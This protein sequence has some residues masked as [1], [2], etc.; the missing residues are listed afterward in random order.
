MKSKVFLALIST[1]I[2]FGSVSLVSANAS[3]NPPAAT[4]TQYFTIPS[5]KPTPYF[6]IETGNS[7][8]RNVFKTAFN[9]WNQEFDQNHIKAHFRYKN[10]T[11]KNSSVAKHAY[12]VSMISAKKNTRIEWNILGAVESSTIG[13]GLN[14]VNSLKEIGKYQYSL[15]SFRHVWLNSANV[16]FTKK[17]NVK[18]RVSRATLVAEH[19]LG[20]VLGLGHNPSGAETIMTQFDS[21]Y[22]KTS[23]KMLWDNLEQVPIVTQ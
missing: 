20:H 14:G 7:T 23:K 19:E 18:W 5:F 11:S 22:Y 17:Q 21:A 1:G 8:Y 2:L 12:T 9:K 13:P 6:Y 3:S 10:A 4:P 16:G 15:G